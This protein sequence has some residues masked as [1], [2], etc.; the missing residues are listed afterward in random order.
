[1]KFLITF[2]II[3]LFGQINFFKKSKASFAYDFLYSKYDIRHS[4]VKEA[5]FHLFNHSILGQYKLCR[6]TF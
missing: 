3:K 6:K 2:L 4:S 1:M 5:A